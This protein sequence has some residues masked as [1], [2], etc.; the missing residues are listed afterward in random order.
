MANDTKRTAGAFDI[1]TFIAALMGVYGVV[2]TLT[3]IL[4]GD[5][6]TNGSKVSGNPNLY[7]G[8]ALI[9][10][11]ALMQGWALWRPTVVDVKQLESEKQEEEGQ[12]PVH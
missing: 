3:G 8:I 10:F 5:T 12:P 6:A 4:G 1:R 2:L 7:V 11:A 9:V